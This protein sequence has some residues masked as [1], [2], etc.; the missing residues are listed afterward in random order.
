MK[1]KKFEVQESKQK[2]ESGQN[3]FPVPHKMTPRSLFVLSLGFPLNWNA[4]MGI[5][6]LLNSLSQHSCFRC[7][8]QIRRKCPKIPLQKS[9][10]FPYS[11]GIEEI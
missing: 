10:E 6:S 5:V 3:S 2:S 8:A 4:E 9:L 7:V 11:P 1:T